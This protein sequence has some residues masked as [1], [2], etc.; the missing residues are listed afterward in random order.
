[1]T[2]YNVRT[3]DLNVERRQGRPATLP[4]VPDMQ[5]FT[6]SVGQFGWSVFEHSTGQKI[7]QHPIRPRAAAVA[8]A[9]ARL[10]NIGLDVARKTVRR[11]IEKLGPVN[12]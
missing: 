2:T 4:A 6:V 8:A 10:L 5:F 9:N 1:M 7:S 12:P 11:Q 3:H